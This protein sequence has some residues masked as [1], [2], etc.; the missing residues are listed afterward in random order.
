MPTDLA[1]EVRLDRVALT[2]TDSDEVV[3]YGFR[4][5]DGREPWF[6]RSI[7]RKQDVPE[8]ELDLFLFARRAARDSGDQQVLGCID[9]VYGLGEVVVNG[10]KI[11]APQKDYG[12]IQMD[13]ICVRAPGGRHTM[14]GF[15]IWS[16]RTES[17]VVIS[18]WYGEAVVP[19]DPQALLDFVKANSSKP[20]NDDVRKALQD[21]LSTAARDGYAVVNGVTLPFSWKREESE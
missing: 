21:A 17:Q 19:Q 2:L 15:R 16:S 11:S 3:S 9:L 13:R 1:G 7:W 14:W 4:I 5:T 18:E 10:R 8:H 6:V 12:E 20:F